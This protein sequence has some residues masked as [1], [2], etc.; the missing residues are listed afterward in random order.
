MY[1]LDRNGGVSTWYAP[2]GTKRVAATHMSSVYTGN[3]ENFEIREIDSQ[4]N[5]V[6]II[7]RRAAAV[8]LS[9]AAIDSF[10]A[11]MLASA[12]TDAARQTRLALFRE[13]NYPLQ[14]SMYDDLRVDKEG[15]VWVRHAAIAGT[16]A[17]W[18]VFD[19]VGVWL[20]TLRLPVRFEVKEI[21]SSYILGVA[22]DILGVEYIE[23]YGLEKGS[24]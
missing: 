20:G 21:G 3:G 16:S 22:T 6:R 7:R 23:M 1:R 13:W 2:F 19:S 8:Q 15:N 5:L 14:R 24:G 10:E 12:R 9:Q 11:Q 17:E 18:S 4:G